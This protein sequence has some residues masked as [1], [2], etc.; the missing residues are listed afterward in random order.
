MRCMRGRTHHVPYECLCDIDV[1]LCDVRDGSEVARA[2][3]CVINRRSLRPMDHESIDSRLNSQREMLD[4]TSRQPQ[5]GHES[6][7][8][9]GCQHEHQG[10]DPKQAL[11]PPRERIGLISAQEPYAAQRIQYPKYAP[12]HRLQEERDD[13]RVQ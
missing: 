7:T 10:I 4:K 6:P 12:E 13:S 1:E 5:D 8:H 11:V 3:E 2:K 9:R